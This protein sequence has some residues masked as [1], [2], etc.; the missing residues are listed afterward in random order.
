MF[1]VPR[2][3]WLNVATLKDIAEETGLSVATV[4]IILNGSAGAKRFRRQTVER[5]EGTA[6]R[7]GYRRDGTRRRSTPPAR[8]PGLIQ[9]AREAGVSI[10]TASMVL[11]GPDDRLPF[12]TELVE[13]V[14]ETAGRLGYQR[15]VQASRFRTRRSQTLGLVVEYLSAKHVVDLPYWAWVLSGLDFA[16][17]SRGYEV[18]IVG[19][20][21]PLTAIEHG[22][23]LYQQC[24]V[25]GLVLP[26]QPRAQARKL[27]EVFEGPV[28]LTARPRASDVHAVFEEDRE[29]VRMLVRHLHELGHRTMAW[30][31]PS[32][33]PGGTAS[34]RR[35]AVQR[36][37]AALGMACVQVPVD[38]ASSLKS[39]Q[40]LIEASSHAARQLL[41]TRSDVTAIACFNDD[42]ALGVYQAAHGCERTIPDQLSVTGYDDFHGM[43]FHPGLTTIRSSI[44]KVGQ[45]AAAW[46]IEHIASGPDQPTSALRRQIVPELI[47]R[48]S[49][50]G[51]RS[52]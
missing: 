5:V 36:Q 51:P 9:V 17:R 25:D 26:G 35:E 38:S 3:H 40:D 23:A 48:Q 4:S 47:V 24:R 11:N 37:T 2:E 42:C 22:I 34:V 27:L 28:V 20:Q 7:M 8:S 52:R 19:P 16:A 43:Y 1:G 49:T 12:R 50:A 46:L 18:V 33:W 31:S 13:R 10:A 32:Q 45:E 39:K 6:R 14:R 30:L 41:K 29:G 21:A 15:N 44:V